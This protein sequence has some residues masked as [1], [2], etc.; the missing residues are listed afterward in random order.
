MKEIKKYA[1]IHMESLV[2]SVCIAKA[3]AKNIVHMKITVTAMFLRLRLRLRL[4]KQ[5][6]YSFIVIDLP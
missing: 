2:S 3:V 1:C 4:T 6:M 5:S